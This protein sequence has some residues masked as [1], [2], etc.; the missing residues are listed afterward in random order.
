MPHS[1]EEL[2][3]YAASM[4]AEALKIADTDW[5]LPQLYS[6]LADMD[7]TV[8]HAHYSRYVVDLNRDPSGRSLYPGQNVTELCPTT[9]FEEEP[10]YRAGEQPHET[11][12]RARVEQYWH[13]YHAALEAELER[14]RHIHGYA[15]LWDAHSIRSVVPRFFDGQL[16]DFNLGTND[17]QSCDE[18]LAA[19]VHKA[20]AASGRYSA[21]MN[22]RFKGG[23]ITRKYGQ[24]DKNIHAIQLELSQITYMEESFPFSYLP[25]D[26][27][28]VASDIKSMIEV[29]MNWRP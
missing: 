25:D 1:G 2:G 13:P 10:V 18:G 9:T 7:V 4:T 3:P 11:E 16:P 29:I 26:A 21:V 23:F 5:H 6:F 28:K 8:L 27:E 19:E 20:A 22:G 17:G 12:Q 15:V 24:P 14:V